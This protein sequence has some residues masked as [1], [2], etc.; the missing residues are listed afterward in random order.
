MKRHVSDGARDKL[1]QRVEKTS[2]GELDLASPISEEAG[3]GIRETLHLLAVPGMLESI[4]EGM[5]TPLRDC[6]ETLDW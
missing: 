4:H 1:P 6:S 5:T 3:D 2:S